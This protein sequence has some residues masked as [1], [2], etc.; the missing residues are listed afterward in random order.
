[1]LIPLSGP[2]L[3][4]DFALIG[5]AALSPYFGVIGTLLLLLISS[6]PSAGQLA[7]SSPSFFL[8]HHYLVVLVKCE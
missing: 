4:R 6:S 1:M 8:N 7:L 5:P 3:S 2:V